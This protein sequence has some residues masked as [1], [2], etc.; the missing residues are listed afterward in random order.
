MRHDNELEERAIFLAAVCGQ[1]YAQFTNTD[2]S[3]VVPLHYSVRHTIQAKSASKVQ[4]RFGFILESPTEIIIAFR[5][6]SSTTDWVSNIKASQKRFKY[7]KENALTHRG[8]TDIYSSARN[9]IISTI[10][11]LSPDKTLYITGHSLGGALATLCAVDIAANTT[12]NSPYLFTFG[13]PRV[14]DPAFTKAFASYVLNTYR[15]ANHFDVVPHAPPTIY[16]LPKREKRYYYHHI[17]TLSSLSFQNGSIAL[18]HMIGN[19]FAE[20]AQLKPKFTQL[21]CLTNPGFCPVLEVNPQK[22]RSVN[23]E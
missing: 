13:S 23:V 1:T 4:E 20:L 11:K 19:Y 8:F 16:K 12:C 6:T 17:Q 2:G 22:S 5:G 9:G 18:N 3:F 21:L 14:G 15:I 7:I 10:S